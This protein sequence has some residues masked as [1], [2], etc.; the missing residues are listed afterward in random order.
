VN[1]LRG[2]VGR[3]KNR[4]QEIFCQRVAEG[5]PLCHAYIKAGYAPGGSRANAS[6]L[7]AKTRIAC[8]IATLVR[9]DAERRTQTLMAVSCALRCESK[10]ASKSLRTACEE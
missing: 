3:L 5:M 7:V 8:R 2:R 1:E 6:R 10:S 9:A 4:Q